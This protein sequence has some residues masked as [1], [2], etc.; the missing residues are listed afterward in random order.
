MILAVAGPLLGPAAPA[1]AHASLLTSTPAAGY[2]VSTSPRA[3]TL[4]FDQPVAIGTRPLQLASDSR[5]VAIG[6]ARLTHGDRWLSADVPTRLAPGVYTVRWQVSARDGDV[7]GG[8]YTFGVG[9]ADVG[10]V[11]AAHSTAT[12]GLTEA[13]VLRWVL[14]GALSVAL[15]GLAGLALVR[16]VVDKAG[17]TGR[18]LPQPAAP[19][20]AAAVVGAV[21]A[22]GL[23]AH[24]LGSGDIVRGIPNLVS[25]ALLHSRAGLIDAVEAAAFILAALLAGRARAVVA[26]SL[27][28]VVAGE[29]Q[30][31]H[32]HEV[33]GAFGSGLVAVHLA[34]AAVW[35]GTLTHVITV[36]WRWRAR[37]VAAHRIVL[38]YAR[39]A[40][41]LLIVVL[42]TGAIAST[43]VL[44]EP[45]ELVTTGY[46]R[47]LL[48]K[49][50]L[51]LAV[52]GCAVVARRR[53]SETS[54]LRA[55][56]DR[57]VT[58]PGPAA[59]TERL[60][61]VAV[62]ACTAVLVSIAA[63]RSAPAGFLAVPPPDGPV[64]PLAAL[65]GEI[66]VYAT[67]SDGR[68]EVRTSTPDPTG[69]GSGSATN[70]SVRSAS[71]AQIA[72]TRCG[73]ACFLGPT[74]WISGA[75]RVS[76]TAASRQWTGG[77]AALVVP[78]PPTRDD[79]LLTNAI[80][81]MRKTPRV[82][83]HETVTSNSA[84]AAPAP[85]TNTLTG[86]DFVSVE[87]YGQ[88]GQLPVI[89]LAHD[90]DL[91]TIAFALVAENYYFQLT[92]GPDDRIQGE[93]I[94]TPQHLYTRTF[95]YP[96]PARQDPSR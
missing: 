77:T 41:A 23:A 50:A 46:G 83:V 89:R 2:S 30:R 11:G 72:L 33:S 47:L 91:T 24:G 5:R 43:L 27:I 94:T 88:A 75:N 69:D 14:F 57:D 45:S 48:T 55:S 3:L 51:V 9:A 44:D 40:L 78:W 28:V 58:Q 67:A 54:P 70:V 19:I 61:L 6:T 80:A 68:L 84:D 12:R 7:V 10:P 82:T 64:V 34:A 13:V 93:I 96:A 35:L 53:L 49:L 1:F 25:T 59:R 66:T 37:R 60:L 32:L 29:S 31:S 74:Q 81:A 95:D 56:A 17:A 86:P 8:Q 26:G 85:T 21:A 90:A 36:A 73:P 39:V 71:G 76:I 18:D 22:L 52:G 20:R 42:G 38:E 65:D 63:P 87:P 16:R 4:V 62:L 15:G 79:R 92:L